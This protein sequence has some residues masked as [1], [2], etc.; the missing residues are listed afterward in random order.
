MN[1]H[2]NIFVLFCINRVRVCVIRFF[3]LND[4]ISFLYDNFTLITSLNKVVNNS[5]V[6]IITCEIIKTSS[7]ESKFIRAIYFMQ[8]KL[9]SILK[10]NV[11][12]IHRLLRFRFCNF[13]SL[14]GLY[15]QI[16]C[17]LALNTCHH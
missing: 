13:L 1:Q 9:A 4:I 10:R 5:L 6:E 16:L 11:C 17:S 3:S 12:K 15:I 14:R 7:K 2:V 8:N